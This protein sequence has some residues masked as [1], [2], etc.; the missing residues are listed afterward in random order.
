MA[1]NSMA[2]NGASRIVTKLNGPVVTTSRADADTIV[3]EHGIAELRGQPIRERVRRMIAI[4]HPDV[5]EGLL[6]DASTLIAGN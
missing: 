5:R 6:R 3:T 2:G 1:L 4:A